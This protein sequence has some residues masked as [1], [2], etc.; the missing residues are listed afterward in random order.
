MKRIDLQFPSVI[1]SSRFSAL[2]SQI[3]FFV[4]GL[5][6]LLG[7]MSLLLTPRLTSAN[8]R[9]FQVSLPTS[10]L[11]TKHKNP[12]ANQVALLW[13]VNNWQTLPEEDRPAGTEL[14]NGKMFPLMLLEG[15][16]VITQLPA[17]TT[18]DHG[19]LTIQDHNDDPVDVWD[20]NRDKGFQIVT[21]ETDTVVEIQ[22]ARLPGGA[23]A[24]GGI[25]DSADPSFCGSRRQ[26]SNSG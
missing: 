5:P 16:R 2:S 8:S 3:R 24:A 1:Y 25:P 7:L 19:F 6:V 15:D 9:G 21:T 18:A 12:A 11:E 4:R 20:A 23:F 14:Q 10:T 22:A 26:G 13:R 17:W